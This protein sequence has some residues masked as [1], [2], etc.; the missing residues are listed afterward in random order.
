MFAYCNN[1][2]VNN[3]D[4]SGYYTDGQIHDFVIEDIVNKAQQSGRELKYKR[5]DTW[6]IYDH[7]WRGKTYGFCDLYDFN[8]GEVWEV[9]KSSFSY[10]CTTAYATDQLSNYVHNG[11]LVRKAS[12][13]R[14]VPSSM[15]FHGNQNFTR[16]DLLGNQ[17]RISYWYEGCGIIRYS[18]KIIYSQKTHA[19]LIGLVAG[20][21]AACMYDESMG[22]LFP[23]P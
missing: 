23:Q 7:L 8:T 6:I 21:M 19:L 5:W 18:Y 22:N 1:N 15:L 20:I 10:T 13:K 14:K 12:L 2:P 9:K 4:P 3:A 17:Y 11:F 16:T